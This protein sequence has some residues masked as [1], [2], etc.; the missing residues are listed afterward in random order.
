MSIVISN[1]FVTGYGVGF[2]TEVQFVIYNLLKR[3]V[4]LASVTTGVYDNV[5]EYSGSEQIP[6]PYVTIGEDVFTDNSTDSELMNL[7]SITIHVWAGDAGRAQTKQI[8]GIIYD[9]LNRARITSM[10]F[11]FININQVSSQ[12]QLDSDG[13]TRH[14]IQ[15]FNLMIEEL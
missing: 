5:P 12:S 7:V 10:E 4:K 2:E 11:K 1:G 13:K 14:G 3:S 8:Q 6:F 15:T 9:L